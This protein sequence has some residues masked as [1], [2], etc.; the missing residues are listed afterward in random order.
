[1]A[2]VGVGGHV[3]RGDDELGSGDGAHAGQRLDDLGLCVSAEGVADLPVEALESVVP[4]QDLRGQIGDDLCGGVFAGQ[5]GLLGLGGFHGRGGHA[6][7]VANPSIGQPGGQAG[8][9]AP[10]KW[11][12]NWL[13]SIRSGGRWGSNR[14]LVRV[15]LPVPV[16]GRRASW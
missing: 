14:G 3:A 4:G 8:Q 15:S 10:P 11:L 6:V 2:G 5:G 13:F 1:M 9:A 12:P 16:H 7:R